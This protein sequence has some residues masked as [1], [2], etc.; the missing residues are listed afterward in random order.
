MPYNKLGTQP[1]HCAPLTKSCR[2]GR[3]H[4][5]PLAN[6]QNGS[7]WLAGRVRPNRAASSP[8]R[9]PAR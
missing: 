6:C 7:E 2:T 3:R 4:G 5:A 8:W 9:R 1:F